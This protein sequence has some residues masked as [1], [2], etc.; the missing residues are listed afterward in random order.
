METLLKRYRVNAR[1]RS[2]RKIYNAKIE[3]SLLS[4]NYVRTLII[5]V[6]LEVNVRNE[7]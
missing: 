5:C 1:M 4:Q 3:M 2:V 6:K 7:I